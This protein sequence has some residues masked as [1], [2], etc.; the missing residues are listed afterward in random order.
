MKQLEWGRNSG[1]R[2][3]TAVFLAALLHGLLILGVRFTATETKDRQLPTLEV[4]LVP[5]GDPAAANDSASYI[6]QRNQR[7]SGTSPDRLRTSLP[8]ASESRMENRGEAEGESLLQQSASTDPGGSTVVSSR[9]RDAASSQTGDTGER[10]VY[11]SIPR[12]SRRLPQLGVNAVAADRNLQLR[13]RPAADDQLLADTRESVIAGYLDGWKRRIERVG[14]LNFPNEAR[15]R[16]MSGNPVLEV[17]IEADGR[18][19]GVVVR[20]SSGHAELDEAAVTIVKLASP[21]DPFPGPM[22]ERYPLL[23]LAY[24]WQFLN[25]QLGDSTVLSDTP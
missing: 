22:R 3:M 6:A 16:T 7:G 18:L 17:T 20:R 2:L 9:N 1:D 13:G 19:A 10:P 25:G 15:R 23:R 14:T 8:E 11:Q 12:D 4:L 5:D 24:E 21:F